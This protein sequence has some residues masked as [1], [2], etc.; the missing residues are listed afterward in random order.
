MCDCIFGFFFFLSAAGTE[1]C[2]IGIENNI[3]LLPCDTLNVN[4]QC[5]KDVLKCL[6]RCIDELT[7][8]LT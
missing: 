6:S 5:L 3:F 7:T 8:L 1:M 2:L 4:V